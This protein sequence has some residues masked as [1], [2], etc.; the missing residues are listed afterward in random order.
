MMRPCF[1]TALALSHAFVVLSQHAEAAFHVASTCNGPCQTIPSSCEDYARQ[2][3]LPTEGWEIVHD[4][5]G[6]PKCR[7]VDVQELCHGVD[8]FDVDTKEKKFCRDV[9]GLT[10]IDKSAQLA[11]DHVWTYD[12]EAVLGAVGA[13]RSGFT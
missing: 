12:N 2:A 7:R 5:E 10:W 8:Y 6:Q 9:S 13:A 3:G 1:I 11:K 4:S